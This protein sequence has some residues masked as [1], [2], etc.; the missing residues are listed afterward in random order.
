MALEDNNPLIAGL[1]AVMGLEAMFDSKNR[2]EF[3]SRPCACLGNAARA[4]PD[5][6]S[7][8]GFSAP[9]YTVDQIAIHLYTLRSKISHGVDLKEAA[10]DPKYP[11]DWLKSVT[12]IPE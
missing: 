10:R 4:F 1:L 9:A 11:V 2:Q 12:L 7:T 6:N 8:A 3:R 5:W